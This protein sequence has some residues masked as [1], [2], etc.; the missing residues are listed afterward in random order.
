MTRGRMLVLR[1]PYGSATTATLA[2][3]NLQLPCVVGRAGTSTRK[4]EGDGATPL[5]RFRLLRLLYRRDRLRRPAGPLPASPI[6]QQDGWCDAPTDRN[7]NRP[8]A[9]PYPASAETM[10]RD[11]RLYDIV[12]ILDHNQRPRI[13]GAGS[14]I[15]M[16]VARPG[17]KP[18][19]GC[20]ALPLPGLLRLLSH[21]RHGSA[22]AIICP[23]H[24]LAVVPSDRLQC[25]GR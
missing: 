25:G 2:L 13:K 11:D 21:L 20:V 24:G 1:T 5:G 15:F 7:Y 9:L 19:E 22:I 12:V 17:L 23:A 10:W 3:G 6:R 8:V 18:T 14:A 4:R 16:H